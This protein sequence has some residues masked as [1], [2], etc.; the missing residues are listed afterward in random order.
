MEDWNKRCDGIAKR[1]IDKRGGITETNQHRFNSF[2]SNVQTQLPA[3]YAQPP[4]PEVDRRFKDSDPVGRA[5]AELLQRCASFALSSQD[6]HPVFKAAVLDYLLNARAVL[7]VRYSPTFKAIELGDQPDD[8]EADEGEEVETEPPEDV[9]FEEVPIDYVHRKDFGHTE[10]RT[11]EEVG[12]LWRRTFLTRKQLVKRFG[13]EIG[14]KVPLNHKPDDE[15]AGDVERDRKAVVYEVWDKAEREAVWICKDHPEELDCRPDPL[16]LRKFF[17]CPRPLFGTLTNDSLVPTP[18]FSMYQDQA[19]DLDELTARISMVTKS[20]KVA[21]VY[22]A[23][24]QGVQR[25]LNEGVE[26]TLIPVDSWAAFAEKGGL[27]GTIELLPLRDIAE[28]L[29]SMYAARE[30]VKND[31]YEITGLS[32]IMRGDTDAAETATAQKIKGN[33][34]GMRFGDRRKDVQH[35][36]RDAIQIMVEII[37]EHFQPETL[38]QMSGLQM[39]DTVAQKQQAAAMFSGQ[40]PQQPMPGMMG[41]GPQQ[42]PPKPDEAMEQRLTSPTWEEVLAMLHN[43]ALR[44]FRIDIETDSTVRADE[45]QEKESAL[46]YAKTVG[47]LLKEAGPIVA[48]APQM[49]PL[50]GEVL[51]FVSRR[52]KIGRTLEGELEHAIDEMKKAAANPPPPQPPIDLLKIQAQGEVDAKKMQ[53]Q[54]QIQQQ[55]DAMKA[56][57]EAQKAQASMAIAQ[58]KAQLDA[59]L[60]Q[61]RMEAEARVAQVEQQAQAQQNTLQ[62]QLEAQKAQMQAELDAAQDSAQQAFDQWKA[63]LDASTKIMVAQI[64]AK[65]SA[66]AAQ[67]KSE[68]AARQVVEKDTAGQEQ[69]AGLADMH[70]KT[71]QA[72]NGVMQQMSKPRKVVR[73]DQGR[74]A[75]VE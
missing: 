62:Q 67:Q 57:G 44:T 53:F 17:P 25:L 61:A 28:A 9:E 40:Q 5:C 51:L 41:A 1:Y 37:A 24:A 3:M 73:D 55:T 46:E 6:A 32:D 38:K 49:G 43:D 65:A 31:M 60:E 64:A 4:K 54:A 18:D 35:F 22:D 42:P 8:E 39:F 15:T 68:D 30:H 29:L 7:W 11:W 66:D 58:H 74:V 70:A 33:F 10:A 63:E 69:S 71:L 14:G 16:K 2:W 27:K 72:I 19:N 23:S 20:L 59:Q 45:A 12:A 75:G 47:G 50:L 56:Q 26:N 21:G 48:G 13:V 52:F 34:A 36:L